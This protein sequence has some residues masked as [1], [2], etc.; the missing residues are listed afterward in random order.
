M[1]SVFYIQTNNRNTPILNDY[2]VKFTNGEKYSMHF[3]EELDSVEKTND[4]IDFV[5]STSIDG[6]Y[7]VVVCHKFD[8]SSMIIQ[9]KLL[10]TIENCPNDTLQIYVGEEF[11]LLL[12]TIQ[13]RVIHV[14]DSIDVKYPNLNPKIT[15]LIDFYNLNQN[16]IKYIIESDNIM[17]LLNIERIIKQGDFQKLYILYFKLEQPESFN[18]VIIN[19]IFKD[20]SEKKKYALIKTIDEFEKNIQLNCNKKLQMF[21]L[22]ATLIKE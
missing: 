9:N 6:A 14:K 10:K 18:N 13:S 15:D 4:I 7:K 5:N 19:I 12:K 21:S 20:L 2:I 16:D 22:L 1:N 17:E 3:V 11:G 8:K